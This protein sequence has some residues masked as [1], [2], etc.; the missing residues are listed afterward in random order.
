MGASSWSCVEPWSGSVEATFAAAQAREFVRVFGGLPAQDRPADLAELWS[1][2]EFDETT[3]A[4]F[5][6]AQG[7]HSILDI[8]EFV[9]AAVDFDSLPEGLTMRQAPAVE[10]AEAFG[11]GR[12]SRAEFERL[13]LRS[14][15]FG[16]DGRGTGRCV[17]LYE[18][19]AP[20]AVA[21]WGHSGD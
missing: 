1:G 17:V 11:H 9:P 8:Y 19:G 18:A 21:F 7:T 20:S 13:P 2:D 12:P 15:L 10:V 6:C 3:W 14:P 5:M 16:D 4:G